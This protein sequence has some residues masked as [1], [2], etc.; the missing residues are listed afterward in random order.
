MGGEGCRGAGFG[1]SAE[2]L[3]LFSAGALGLACAASVGPGPLLFD[4]EFD[5]LSLDGP[6]LGTGSASLPPPPGGGAGSA[7]HGPAPVVDTEV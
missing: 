6:G 4:D 2:L 3:P 7:R 1:V 5:E